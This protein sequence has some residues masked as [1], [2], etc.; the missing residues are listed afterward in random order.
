MIIATYGEVSD[1]LVKLGPELDVDEIAAYE[2]SKTWAVAASDS[3][4]EAVVLL[5]YD[6][7]SK[8]LF[9]S[10]DCGPA[11]EDKLLTTYE[12]LLK[13]NL[14]CIDTG[15]A[16]F[17]LDGPGGEVSLIFDVSLFGLEADILGT[18]IGNFINLLRTMQ[19]MV[20]CG[21][22]GEKPA[23]GGAPD[24]DGMSNDMQGMI[25]A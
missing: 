8:K 20:L 9:I 18:A 16:R 25:R 6:E 17:A 24:T 7:A 21:F 14:A 12:F 1:M 22:D 15:G 19:A 11:P 5:H 23:N 4:W 2:E 3:G 10:G 13:Y